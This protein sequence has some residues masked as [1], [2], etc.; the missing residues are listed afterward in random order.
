M[1]LARFEREPERLA[2]PQE[3]ALPYD[4][5]ERARAQL[6]RKRRR[7]FALGEKIIH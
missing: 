6:L 5:V 3:M 7:G 1:G 4:L 2:R